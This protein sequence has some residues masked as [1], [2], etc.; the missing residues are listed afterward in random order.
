MTKWI[1]VKDGLP[2]NSECVLI[3]DGNEIGGSHFFSALRNP[4][5]GEVVERNVWGNQFYKLTGGYIKKPTHWM[6]PR[7]LIEE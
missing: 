4:N 7:D 2:P 5:T 6:N 3:T 1:S